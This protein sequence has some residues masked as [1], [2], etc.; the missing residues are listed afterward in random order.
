MST[1]VPRSLYL[2]FSFLIACD[3][4][5]SSF[6][7][8]SNEESISVPAELENSALNVIANDEEDPPEAAFPAGSCRSGFVQ[9]G[10]RLCI[11]HTVQNATNWVG[12]SLACTEKKGRICSYEDL[13]YI[14]YRTSLDASFSPNG[15]HLGN[16]VG[17]NQT[18]YGNKD[19]TTD[20]DPDRYDFDAIGSWF[21]SRP[22]WC[23]HD[24]DE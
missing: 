2:A 23:C 11:S 10:V 4:E 3:T 7:Q 6:A 20:N 8:E 9:A 14:Y 19:I 15:K 24:D 22:Y 12:A 18:L 13:S 16:I 21:D 5:D 1:H 17:D